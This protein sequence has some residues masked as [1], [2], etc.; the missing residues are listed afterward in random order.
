[1]KLPLSRMFASMK[2]CLELCVEQGP[3]QILYR[4]GQKFYQQLLSDEQRMQAEKAFEEG[5]SVTE[6]GVSDLYGTN[7]MM[8]VDNFTGVPGGRIVP[9]TTS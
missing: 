6:M 2:Q 8:V 3:K 4:Q 5:R 7:I 1:M 9:S